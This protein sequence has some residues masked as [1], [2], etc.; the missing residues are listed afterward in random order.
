MSITD[1]AKSCNVSISKITKYSKKLGFD[2]YKELKYEINKSKNNNL[3]LRSYDYQRQKI[4]TF[5]ENF[6]PVKMDNLMKYINSSEKVYFYGRGPSLKVAEYYVPRL[7]VATNKNIVSNYDEYL[8]DIDLLKKEEN[9]LMI[10]LTISGKTPQVHEIIKVCKECGI[11]TVVISGYVS[12]KLEK[13]CDLYINL[14]PRKELYDKRVIRGRTL[15]Y[16]YLEIIT[17]EFM[18]QYDN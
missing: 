4:N 18:G 3:T 10:I 1:L 14:L 17:Q 7:R 16:I 5:F 13:N 2:G 9:K 6:D 12:E 8:F 15:F 11:R